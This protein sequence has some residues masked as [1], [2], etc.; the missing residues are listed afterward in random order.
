MVF[1]T[2]NGSIK[3][4]GSFTL[5]NY[6][7]PTIAP[8]YVNN[9]TINFN[10]FAPYTMINPSSNSA[11]AFTYTSSNTNIA[12]VSNNQIIN[13]V[14]VSGYF[15]ITATQAAYG[16][17]SSGSVSATYYSPIN[18]STTNKTIST[19]INSSYGNYLTIP[20]TILTATQST[21]TV[22]AWIYTT[23]FANTSGGL[24]PSF[25]GDMM[26]SN[27]NNN[28]SFGPTTNGN[29]SMYIWQSTGQRYCIGNT[30][31]NTNSWY[32]ISVVSN[33]TNIYLY[34]NGV[35]DAAP[36]SYYVRGGTQNVTNIGMYNYSYWYTGYANNIRISNIAR[37][38]ANFTPSAS[39]FTNDS[40][41]LLLIQ[42]NGTNFAAN[43]PIF[44]DNSSSNNTIIKVGYPTTTSMSPYTSFLYLPTAPTA[45]T[46]GP[47][48]IN[49]PGLTSNPYTMIDPSSNSTGLFTY[50][51]S[52]TS[53][54]TVSNRCVINLT[55]V[56]GY[57]T[58]TATQAAYGS[59]TSGS[60]SA[61]YYA[62]FNSN[63]TNTT[64][65]IQIN[66]SYWNYLTIPKTILPATQSI[67]TVEAWIYTTTFANTS[68]ASLPSF[69]GDTIV[70]S[71]A[72]A[73]SFGP[74]T[75]GKLSIYINSSSGQQI[76]IG[77][78]VMN[79]NTWYHISVVSDGLNI[80][81]YLNGVQ[82][83]GSIP[84]YNLTNVLSMPYYNRSS[85][86][87]VTNIGFLGYSYWYTGYAN[88]IRIS[89]SARYLT[90]FTPSISPFTSDSNTMFLLQYNG[91]NFV[92]NSPTPYAITK[93]GSPSVSSLTPSYATIVSKIAPTIPALTVNN[94]LFSR[95][96]VLGTVYTIIDPSS[97][98]TGAFTYIS[99]N[100]SVATITN[101]RTFTALAVGTTTITVTQ[102]DAP[103]YLYG[104]ITQNINVTSS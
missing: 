60:V 59:Y 98:S 5:F 104:I 62:A 34:L 1:F 7:A 12:T 56:S 87:S 86:N 49:N 97:N 70:S 53:M 32:H 67:F 31:M 78:S 57:V 29:L 102:A 42:Y 10:S 16:I 72:D 36:I 63:T 64:K 44:L 93:N 79:T 17:Y 101:T 43:S 6:T 27:Q 73:W 84:V 26:N 11:G 48:Y 14:G 3:G 77:N 80:Y 81:L 20:N 39:P 54:A 25:I 71:T 68:L 75:S 52:N 90:N 30:V 50:T 4:S 96:V 103:S 76:F 69:I 21:F 85:T 58:I 82:E 9:P 66:S 28:W 100:V 24:T 8:L 22:E 15:T 88:N 89:N 65:S 13:L 18:N 46:I 19:Q 47:L 61:T 94:S 37:Y 95:N 51:I 74:I 35:Q 91:T 83:T 23:T 41:T 45:P 92:D 55:G 38:T 99:S 2:G 40:N 33:G